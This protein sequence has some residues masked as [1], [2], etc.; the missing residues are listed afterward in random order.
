MTKQSTDPHEELKLKARQ[1]RAAILSMTTLAGAG[2]PG[3]SLSSID[4]LLALY[5]D[6][7][8]NPE[9]PYFPQRDRVVVSNGHISPAVYATLA[10]SGYYGLDEAISQYRL[11]G[12]IFEG[13]IEREV[14]GVEWST[15]NLGQGLSAGAGMALASRIKDIPYRVYVLM[16]DGEQQKGQISEARRFASKYQLDNLTAIVDYNGLQISGEISRVMPQNIRANWESDGW[17]VLEI[18]G[19]DYTAIFNALA[20]ARKTAQPILILARTVMGKG[21]PFMENQAKYHGAAISEA[22]LEEAMQI[23][24]QPN[25]MK[26][27]KDLRSGFK[28][29]AN[30]AKSDQF[31]LSCEL[32]LGQPILYEKET[33][34]RSAW[35]TAIADLAKVNLKKPTPIV[36]LDCDLQASVKTGDFAQIAPERFVQCGISEHHTAVMGGAL[37]TCGIQTFWADFG[38]FGLDEVY[39]QQRLNDINHTNLKSVFTHVGLDVGEDGKTHQCIDYIGLLR[40]LYGTRLIC[41]ADPNHTDRI[42]RWLANKPGNYIVVM[43]RSKL[44][45]LRDEDGTPF[46]KIDYGFKYGQADILRVGNNGSVFVTG[47]PAGRALEAVERLREEGVFLQLTYVSCPLSLERAVLESAARTGIIFSIEDHNIHSGLGSCIADRLAEEGLCARLVKLGVGS[48]GISGRP[49]DLYKRAGISSGA[50]LERIRHEL[51]KND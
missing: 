19:H 18:D 36:V 43:G 39:N 32:E 10:L 4:L 27:Y 11:T 7:S 28:A 12:S 34:N 24:G 13:H 14:P 46:Y 41:P 42:I 40:N 26:E 6:I 17:Q 22:Q 47:T 3:G 15:G 29:Q 1:A 8:Y 25:R 45:I 23:L 33:D 49:E 5:Q 35:G 51:Q 38:V 31:A 37:S 2:H 50:I 16:G 20:T 9:Q 30:G 21:V 48:Y 44:P